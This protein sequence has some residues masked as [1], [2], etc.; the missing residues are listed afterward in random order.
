MACVGGG[1]WAGW[2]GYP[3]GKHLQSPKG[4]CSVLLV[5]SMSTSFF[6]VFKCMAIK[7]RVVARRKGIPT[8]GALQS[9]R[10]GRG[11]MEAVAP[12][13]S[14]GFPPGGQTAF[15]PGA[16]HGHRPGGKEYSMTTA[17]GTPASIGAQ[18]NATQHS[19]T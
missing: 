12:G 11:G 3:I 10:P 13:A 17:H 18:Q 19:T 14:E 2:W 8:P 4:S 16:S 7:E 9:C 1:W 6:M 5:M 15:P